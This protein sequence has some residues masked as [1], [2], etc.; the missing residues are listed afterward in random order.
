MS[1]AP[2]WKSGIRRRRPPAE[3]LTFQTGRKR[4]SIFGGCMRGFMCTRTQ[5]K[6]SVS[7]YQTRPDLVASTGGPPWGRRGWLW[8]TERTKTLT[9]I[10]G[11]G[12]THW[13]KLSWKLPFSHQ[14]QPVGSN[15]R[16]PQAK[17][18]T[19]WEH[20][21]T[22]Q[23]TGCLKSSWAYSHPLNTLLDTPL[24]SQNKLCR[25]E[26]SDIIY[27]KWCKGKTYKLEHTAQQGS[28]SDLT[29]QW[30]TLQSRKKL[31]EFSTT[32]EA[33]QQILKKNKKGTTT[34]RK[35]WMEKLT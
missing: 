19:W 26:G 27:W 14:D 1:G 23:Q 5:E 7:W 22:H 17:Q 33:L 32:W 4:N 8:L 9:D 13:H 11:S 24:I 31:R 2:A 21:P 20:S 34:N 15:A 16:K 18:Q 3:N 28:Q 29:E 6:K 30:K 35:L 10:G 12:S 25:Q